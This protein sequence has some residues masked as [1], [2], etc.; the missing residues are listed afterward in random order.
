MA[1]GRRTNPRKNHPQRNPNRLGPKGNHNALHLLLPLPLHGFG[2]PLQCL[3]ERPTFQPVSL[4]QVV[5][6]IT[7]LHSVFPRNHL[8]R[9]VQDRRGGPPGE[10][11]GEGERGREALGQVR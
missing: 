9:A 11:T 10:A 8:G 4:P 5:D 6:P 7:L 3:L 1:Q 2:P